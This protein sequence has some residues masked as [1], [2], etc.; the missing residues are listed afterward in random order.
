MLAIT[1]SLTGLLSCTD[2]DIAQTNNH[3]QGDV[4]NFGVVNHATNSSEGTRTLYGDRSTDNTYYPVYWVSG[5]AIS[6]YCPEAS[7]SG[8]KTCSYDVTPTAETSSEGT[9]STSASANALTWG[10]EGEHQFYAVYPES[11]INTVSADNV[12]VDCY[13]PLLQY[14]D[15]VEYDNGVYTVK[16]NMKYAYMWA[17]NTVNS[18]DENVSLTFYPVVST[19][20]ITIPGP[21]ENYTTDEVINVSQ[22]EIKQ[23]DNKPLTGSFKMSL[24]DGQLTAITSNDATARD[25]FLTIPTYY[26]G[27][28]IA[29]KRGEKIV[30]KAFI[31]PTLGNTTA[32]TDDGKTVPVHQND[33]SVTVRMPAKGI[34]T[35]VLDKST[36][37]PGK[38]NYITLPSLS[39][40]ETEYYHWMSSL[41]GDTYVSQLSIPGGHNSYNIDTEAN[42][43]SG[44]EG[45]DALNKIFQTLSINDQ[46]E[47]G[48]RAFTCIV[49]YK[50]G[51]PNDYS[52]DTD[53]YLFSAGDNAVAKLDDVIAEYA[54]E[55][56]NM[57]TDYNDAYDE[58]T[59]PFK[60]F[61]VLSI[62]L[63]QVSGNRANEVKHWL[64]DLNTIIGTFN[65]TNPGVLVEG[66]S[67][68]TTVND[69]KG[70]ILLLVNY[71]A[72]DFASEDS[73]T[74]DIND[75]TCY[76][77]MR[78]AYYI[79]NS[80]NGTWGSE[81][82]CSTLGS[83]DS[84]NVY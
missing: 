65:E 55:L 67:S 70:K 39:Y 79:D 27:K 48:A 30:V 6:I 10:E 63:K 17:Y 68:G 8:T 9:L 64:K 57:E 36:I 20:E 75:A 16:P 50:S 46:L 44:D 24:K 41:N 18:T 3:K 37:Y 83:S 45:D 69:L 29:L 25:S 58:E 74:Y 33:L 60:E 59:Y 1:V 78:K 26:N 66:L 34:R 13:I 73:Y 14:P 71:Q 22:I 40:P 61:I 2:D 49:G 21:S 54:S 11:D 77:V 81:T 76:N 53:L 80:W 31:L 7:N 72:E 4:I 43:V 52:T 82:D 42:A 84:H 38:V 15:T 62:D 35:K 23:N 32:E 5:D 28:P 56:E 19:L 47:N 12:T 51:V